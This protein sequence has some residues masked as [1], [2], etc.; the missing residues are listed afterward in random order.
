MLS[1][2]H[3]DDRPI[4]E[5]PYAY[6]GP[7]GRRASGVFPL[8][9]ARCTGLPAPLAGLI[10]ASDLQGREPHWQVKG[11]RPPRLLG[12]LLA[13]E[14]SV[15][16]ELGEIPPLDAIGVLLAGDLYVAPGLDKRGGKGD[17]RGVWEAFCMRFRWVAGVAGNHDQFGE[18]REEEAAFRARPCPV[19]LDGAIAHLDGVSIGGVSG[20]IGNP[21]RPFRRSEEAFLREV[22]CVLAR[23]PDILVL[24][25]GPGIH[26]D[27]C[28][29]SDPVTRLLERRE[30]ALTLCGHTAWRSPR[31]CFLK[32]GM[33]VLNTAGRGYVI[34][35]ERG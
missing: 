31:A 20:V 12:E 6:P 28:P 23:R 14:L 3:I 35:A 26:G 7:G 21:R 4:H 11:D 10:A 30:A 9:S 5:M 2:T 17:V 29:G 18:T 34:T 1:L 27:G 8:F 32:G 22:E 33:Q 25:E 24:H 13:E 19:L 16:S 15:L